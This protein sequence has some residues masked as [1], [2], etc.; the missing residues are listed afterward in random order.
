MF[1]S[2]NSPNGST[3]PLY[4]SCCD[5]WEWKNWKGW[6]LIQGAGEETHG[7]Q[8]LNR[9]EGRCGTVSESLCVNWWCGRAVWSPSKH[10]PGRTGSTLPPFSP[11]KGFMIKEKEWEKRNI[12]FLTYWSSLNLQW[13]LASQY[14]AFKKPKLISQKIAHC[15][16]KKQKA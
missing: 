11:F 10:T 4:H 14:L 15:E 7:E 2:G 9:R 12:L 3:G 8:S 13:T 1:L 6:D 5:E 16:E